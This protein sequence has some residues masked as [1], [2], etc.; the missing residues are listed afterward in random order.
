MYGKPKTTEEKQKEFVESLKQLI[1]TKERLG[2][3]KD[4]T[5]TKEKEKL[6]SLTKDDYNKQYA[7]IVERRNI[8]F[9]DVGA[10]PTASTINRGT[11]RWLYEV[12]YRI[13]HREGMESPLFMMGQKQDRLVQ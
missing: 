6:D 5:Y 8:G 9:L 11:G 10:V 3:T 7:Q 2:L 12:R 4:A 1:E 13:D